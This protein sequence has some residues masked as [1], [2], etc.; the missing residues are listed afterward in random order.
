MKKQLHIE[1]DLNDQEL[2]GNTSSHGSSEVAQVQ[3]DS[4]E[5]IQIEIK[6]TDGE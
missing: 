3:N 4:K 5:S 2:N 6:S 1:F